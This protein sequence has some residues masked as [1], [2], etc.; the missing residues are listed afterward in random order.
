MAGEA[1]GL[2]VSVEM[3]ATAFRRRLGLGDDLVRVAVQRR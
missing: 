2:L 1:P 3:D